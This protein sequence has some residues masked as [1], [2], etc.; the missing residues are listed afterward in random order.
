MM[1]HERRSTGEVKS[2]GFGSEE[3]VGRFGE[4]WREVGVPVLYKGRE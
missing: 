2:T 1:V 4:R 3:I